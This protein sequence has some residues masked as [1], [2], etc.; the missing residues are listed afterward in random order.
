MPQAKFVTRLSQ[1]TQPGSRR[2]NRSIFVMPTPQPRTTRS[3]AILLT[4]ATLA[5]VTA[6]RV[7][8]AQAKPTGLAT[9]LAQ[10]NASSAKFTSAQADIR[11][12]LFDS[13]VQDTEIQTGQVYF[14]RK[15]VS[16]QMGMKLSAS[17][18]KPGSPPAQIIEFKDNK[19]QVLNTGTSQVDVFTATG[20]NQALAETMMTLGFGGSGTDL[21]KAWDITDQG[22]EQ[23]SDGSKQVQVEKLDLVSKDP[24][25]RNNYSHITIWVDPARDVSLKQILFEASGG[26]SSGNTRTAVYTNIR[27]N[28]KVNTDAFAIKCPGKC[29]VVQH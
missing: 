6:G 22:S 17:G 23:M 10:M 8:A 25:I 19:A 29:T 9:I 24:T 4:A 1:Q 27:P 26:K 11:Q 3:L 13:R 14:I 28:E 16:T 21:E 12:E 18:A 5:S 2:T 20:K 15:G 7:E